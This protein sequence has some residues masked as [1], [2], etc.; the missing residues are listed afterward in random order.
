M[1][2]SKVMQVHIV[3]LGRARIDIP[4]GRFGIDR[5][6]ERKDK[7]HSNEAKVREAIHRRF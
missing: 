6:R 1:T 7:R 3:D 5:C 4:V 2:R